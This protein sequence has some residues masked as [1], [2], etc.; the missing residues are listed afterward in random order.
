[1]SGP[2]TVDVSTMTADPPVP[3]CCGGY[4]NTARDKDGNF[5][6]LHSLPACDLL[7]KS[8]VTHFLIH[9]RRCPNGWTGGTND[10]GSGLSGDDGEPL[11]KRNTHA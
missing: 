8:E 3:C 9:Q 7:L 5:A 6:V 11:C 4:F 10:N 1:M 2:P